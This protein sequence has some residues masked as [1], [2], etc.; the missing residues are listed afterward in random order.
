VGGISD[1]PPRQ[2]E[3]ARL[4]A[5]IEDQLRQTNFAEQPAR[6]AELVFGVGRTRNVVAPT[7]LTGRRAHWRGGGE[8]SGRRRYLS[9]QPDAIDEVPGVG[10]D[11]RPVR[12]FRTR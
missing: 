9:L 10:N 11:G 4:H 6:P 5:F 3:S 7:S 2:H 12:K 1:G 8:V